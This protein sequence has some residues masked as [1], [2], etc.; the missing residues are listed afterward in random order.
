MEELINNNDNN[1][2]EVEVYLKEYNYIFNREIIEKNK[3]L[4]YNP[5]EIFNIII[6]IYSSDLTKS[7][8]YYIY[9]Y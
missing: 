3:E 8:F 2:E 4:I 5:E 1:K 7:I 9:N 6:F